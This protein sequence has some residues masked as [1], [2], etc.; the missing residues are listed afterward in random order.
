[1]AL[2][3]T[4]A[5]DLGGAIKKFDLSTAVNE[6][7]RVE[8]ASQQAA[9]RMVSNSLNEWQQAGRNIKT[10]IQDIKGLAELRSMVF[11]YS[12]GDQMISSN[13]HRN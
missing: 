1:V 8:G 4:Q 10:V 13:R 5:E 7:G 9:D 11:E 12:Q 2:F 6:F 3:G